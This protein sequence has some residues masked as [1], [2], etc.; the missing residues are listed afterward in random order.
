MVPNKDKIIK[1]DKE[2]SDDQFIIANLDMAGFYRVNYDLENWKLIAKQLLTNRDVN[3]LE[4]KLMILFI[5]FNFLNLIKQLSPRTR[6]QLISD[7]FSLSQAGSVNPE[8]PLDL[9]K[10]LSNEFDYLPWNV[11]ISRVGFYVNMLDTTKLNGDL[12]SFLSA[13]VE[14]Y[15][16]KVGWIDDK[17]QEWLDR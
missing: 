11:F 16:K 5:H 7:I 10:Y 1:L 6:A 17:K 12:Q 15:Y 4:L 9:V 13:L 3:K 8:Q 2:L 14:P